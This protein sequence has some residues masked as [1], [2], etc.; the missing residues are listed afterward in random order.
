MRS[1][2]IL[3]ALSTAALAAPTSPPIHARAVPDVK[4]ELK[5]DF[6]RPVV[7][8]AAPD[9]HKIIEDTNEIV[10]RVAKSTMGAIVPVSDSKF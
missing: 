10:K 7:T 3:I 9:I 5:D 4:I 8:R 1:A 6:A 2:I